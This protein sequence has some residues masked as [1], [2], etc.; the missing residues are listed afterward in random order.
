MVIG[1]SP[2]TAPVGEPPV[3]AHAPPVGVPVTVAESRPLE[4]RQAPK[5]SVAT[6]A[7]HE[8]FA[9]V[10]TDP[11]QVPPA[12]AAQPQVLHARVSSSD[13]YAMCT[14]GKPAGHCAAPSIA[15]HTFALQ[16]RPHELPPHS[17]TLRSQ[18][19]G[20][21]TL[22]CVELAHEPPTAGAV[23][24]T[25]PIVPAQDSRVHP[26]AAVDAPHDAPHATSLNACAVAAPQVMSAGAPH[27]QVQLAGSP[28]GPA[29][30]SYSSD[31]NS[32]PQSAGVPVVSSSLSG[33]RQ[34]EGRTGQLQARASPAS[35]DELAVLS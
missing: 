20:C 6:A 17:R 26:E 15:T 31:G 16:S 12:G 21:I 3:G 1:L 5:G 25:L 32:P 23:T 29:C 9:Y 27:A 4:G 35:G 8:P 28:W 33:P 24:R 34:P 30:P 18:R 11:A 2:R 19:G 10:E 22:D 7:L 13:P 14:L